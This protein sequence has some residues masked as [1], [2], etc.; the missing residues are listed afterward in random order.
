MAT[1][2]QSRAW[3]WCMCLGLALMLSGVVIG[4]VYLCH[5]DVT[6]KTEV[7]VPAL[8]L[9]QGWSVVSVTTVTSAV[10]GVTGH[11]HNPSRHHLTPERVEVTVRPAFTLP[12]PVFIQE[13]NTFF[14]GVVY[15][16][17]D[18]MLMD[19]DQVAEVS[20]S[21]QLTS[22]SR[23]LTGCC[24]YAGGADVAAASAAA[25]GEDSDPGEGAGGARQHPSARVW[26]R[27]PGQNRP[28]LPESECLCSAG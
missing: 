25:A 24:G 1:G 23:R 27:R 28:R 20:R 26:H 7:S 6:E 4:G 11:N 10:F 15:P 17:E 14:C 22:P 12:L 16:E 2:S 19:S 8:L 18:F 5:Y 21:F 13:E 3:C 9:Q